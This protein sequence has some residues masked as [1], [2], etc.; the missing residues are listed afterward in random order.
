MKNAI[1]REMIFLFRNKPFWRLP[2]E[3]RACHKTDLC[4]GDYYLRNS[5]LPPSL[6]WC[7]FISLSIYHVKG[8]RYL[9]IYLHVAQ[10]ADS[11]TVHYTSVCYTNFKLS[12]SLLNLV[13]EN[14]NFKLTLHSL[15]TVFVTKRENKNE[16]KVRKRGLS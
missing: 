7:Q 1:F 8:M 14:V 9:S 10:S 2:I 3:E 15:K 5:G 16:F 6:S 4:G 12:V 13:T 11:S